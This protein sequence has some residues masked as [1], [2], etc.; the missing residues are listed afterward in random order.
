MIV[1]CVMMILLGFVVLAAAFDAGKYHYIGWART[2]FVLGLL[3]IVLGIGLI[4]R[5]FTV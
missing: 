1:I 3:D 4:V 5:S 2:L